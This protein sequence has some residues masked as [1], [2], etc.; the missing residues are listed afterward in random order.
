MATV[1]IV[2]DD[3][4]VRQLVGY[5]LRAAGWETREADGIESAR[6]HIAEQAVAAVVLDLDLAGE[7]GLA[8]LEQLPQPAPFPVILLSGDTHS[9]TAEQVKQLGATAFLTKPFA[10]TALVT[11]L[12]QL[13]PGE[14]E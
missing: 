10:V 3:P 2:D 8:L 14:S 13:V 4:D 11:S 9:T 1:L 6:G 5:A 7:S 12:R